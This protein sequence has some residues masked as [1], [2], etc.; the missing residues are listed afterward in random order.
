MQKRLLTTLERKINGLMLN[1]DC[2]RQKIDFLY[3]KIGKRFWEH[4]YFQLGPIEDITF[5]EGK[6]LP[7][8]SSTPAKPVAPYAY[9]EF[10]H[11]DSVAFACEMLDRL[12]LF[13]KSIKVSPRSKYQI[14][15][16]IENREIS[17]KLQRKAEKIQKKEEKK[18]KREKENEEKI[19]RKQERKEEKLVK[20]WKNREERKSLRKSEKERKELRYGREEML[21]V[22]ASFEIKN[23]V[24]CCFERFEIK[25][26]EELQYLGKHKKEGWYQEMLKVCNISR[27]YKN[28]N[29]R[30]LSRQISRLRRFKKWL[31]FQ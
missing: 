24:A 27:K 30:P 8:N 13:G 12:K 1:L 14:F 4:L 16:M 2:Y 6:Q 28:V 21:E 18:I 9:V 19:R 22:N 20:K 17:K 10:V 11:E 3:K 31:S 7:Q 15:K 29:F 5:Y 23:W 25:E 26:N